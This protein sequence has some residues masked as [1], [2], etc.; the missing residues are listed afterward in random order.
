MKLHVVMFTHPHEYT[1]LCGVFSS[2]E[3]AE[4][5]VKKSMSDFNPPDDFNIEEVELDNSEHDG[6]WHS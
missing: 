4:E 3:K 2:K 1:A 6:E 5:Y